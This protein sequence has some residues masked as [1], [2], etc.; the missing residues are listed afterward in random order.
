VPV[1][2]FGDDPNQDL[3]IFFAPVLFYLLIFYHLLDPA[4]GQTHH[5]L[6]T[7]KGRHDLFVTIDLLT[8]LKDIASQ[9]SPSMLLK[10]IDEADQSQP[11]FSKPFVSI[12]GLAN[13]QNG[14]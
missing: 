4:G 9:L 10:V 6:L 2:V 5:A 3:H 7:D 13:L 8:M 12:E 1:A 11:C 14:F